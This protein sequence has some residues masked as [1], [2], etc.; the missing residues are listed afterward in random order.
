MAAIDEVGVVRDVRRPGDDLALEEDR[1][2]QHDVGQV[3]A[4]AGVGV[5]AD[6]D[7]ALADLRQRMPRRHVLDH[8]H[9]RAEVHRDVHRLAQR[10]AARVEQARRAVAP[11][12][13]V[14]RVGGAHQRLAHLLDDGGERIADHLHRDRIDSPAVALRSG[15]VI[16]MHA[17]SRLSRDRPPPS[18][19][20]GAAWSRP[21]ARRWP[22]RRADGR[23]RGARDRRPDTARSLP[24]SGSQTS[25]GPISAAADAVALAARGRMRA[26]LGAP[27]GA[28]RLEAERHG[29][30]RLLG[31]DVAVHLLVR[32]L[33][34][35]R[36]APRAARVRAGRRAR[37]PAARSSARRSACR[38]CAGCCRASCAMPSRSNQLGGPARRAR[39]TSRP[40]P[41]CA[42]SV[43][44]HEPRP[45]VVGPQ[46]AQQQA[47]RAEDARMARHEDARDLQLAR[48]A[49]GVQRARR[50]RRPPACTRAD[51]ARA[52]P[53]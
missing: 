7:V 43:H 48:Q 42:S 17:T 52:A 2:D 28:D 10:A 15:P 18:G 11:L 22:G 6:E 33:E 29:L 26:D 35:S 14:G 3:R 12:L 4:A 30:D 44:R 39:R 40:S 13:D 34:A 24:A 19:R 16:V 9:Q 47:E 45:R 31:G 27:H 8:A 32:A 25:R 50:R 41:A 36:S 23:A 1:L 38:R 51:R 21:S 37:P 49:R 5:V 20:A 53:R 46:I